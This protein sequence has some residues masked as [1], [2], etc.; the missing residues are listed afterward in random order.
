MPIQRSQSDPVQRLLN[1]LQPGSYVRPH[2]HP[3]PG[4]SE[5]IVVLQ[6]R[7]LFLLFSETGEVQSHSILTGGSSGSLV[8]IEPNIWH[9]FIV[10]EEDTLCAEFKRGPYDP[11]TDKIF[12]SWS[13]EEGSAESAAF[14]ERLRKNIEVR[15]Q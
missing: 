5:T 4:A 1:C 7:L 10:L 12:A 8:D 11:Q 2:K 6:G 14:I 13:P 9:G 3:T 15:P